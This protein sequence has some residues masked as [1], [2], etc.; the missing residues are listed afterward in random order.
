MRRHLTLTAVCLLAAAAVASAAQGEIPSRPEKLVF[1]PMEWNIPDAE[2]L[3]FELA[4]GTPVYALR[5]SQFP[6]VN[7]A[8]YFRGGGYLVPVGREGLETLAD[9]VW[10]TG[11]AG[12]RTA[13]ELDEELDFLAANL[14]IN[15]GDVTGS[16]SLNVLAK[17]LDAAMALMMDVLTKPRFQ[18]D[19][20]AKAKDDLVQ[21]MK[22]RN[23]NTARIEGREWNR[24]IYGDDYFLNRLPT[25]ATVAALTPEMARDFV[26]SLVRS[27]NIVVAVSGDFED[28]AIKALLERTV[29]TLPALDEPLPPIPQPTHT[30]EPGVYV[31]DK[32]DV[33]QARVSYGHLGYRLG[34]PAE[35]ALMVGNDILGGGGFT[36]RM[37]KTIRS[38]E[39]L[40]YSAYSAVGF[41][42]SYPG[43]VRAFFQTKS[44]T[45]AY[46]TEIG[47]GLLEEM[48]T[49]PVTAEELTVS[50][51]QFI[52]T[53][54]RNFASAAQT[55]S[56]FAVDELLGRSHDYWKSYR[57]RVAAVD[58][59]SVL[60]AFRTKVR[61]DDMVI[62]VVGNLAEITAGH[63]DHESQ[64]SDF[65][66]IVEMPLRDPLTLEP[67]TE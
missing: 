35:F 31:I 26:T 37:M 8:V 3:R 28:A 19:R 66:P 57:D 18:E 6:L 62:L 29:G 12:E 13:G 58:A 14:M 34:D 24:L 21:D 1:G 53:F 39:G 64:L 5:D 4:N 67:I 42:T 54:P 63:P 7:I 30:P 56:V 27:D 45:C 22:T 9:E 40:A 15:I 32:P 50:K 17:D 61:P 52:E 38:D 2:S 65:G 23:D 25:Q 33:N 46:A 59:D 60:A 51:N 48:R 49:S 41:P 43:T 16:V 47:F 44:S 10:R 55:V 36:A 20:F 11:G